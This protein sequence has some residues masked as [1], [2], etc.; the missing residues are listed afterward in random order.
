MI[1]TFV[2]INKHKFEALLK[3]TVHYSSLYLLE[4]SII[5]QAL[6]NLA[7]FNHKSKLRNPVRYG[8]AQLS[9]II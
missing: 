8:L 5:I 9:T 2:I 6:A 4:I 3:H 7:R 1:F